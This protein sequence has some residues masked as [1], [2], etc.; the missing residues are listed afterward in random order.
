MADWTSKL[1]CPEFTSILESP[2]AAPPPLISQPAKTMGELIGVCRGLLADSKITTAEVMFLSSWLQGF[3][4]ISEW[5]P[6]EIAHAVERILEDG[7]VKRPKNPTRA[8][9]CLAD[10]GFKLKRN[11]GNQNKSIDDFTTVEW[12]PRQDLNLYS[13]TY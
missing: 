8:S 10:F 2:Q 13:V 7:V 1:E 3:G 12:C 5:P 11:T 9:A 4:P 6:S